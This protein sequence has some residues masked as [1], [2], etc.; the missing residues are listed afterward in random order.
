MA[1]ILDRQA[2]EQLVPALV[3]LVLHLLLGAMRQAIV[4]TALQALIQQ[5]A[6]A[7]V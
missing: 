2:K 4:L 1:L 5:A 3:L 6:V 7:L